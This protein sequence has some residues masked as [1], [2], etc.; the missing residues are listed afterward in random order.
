M[1]VRKEWYMKQLG[2]LFLLGAITHQITHIVVASSL[3][4]GFRQA[5][6]NVS[7]KLGELVRCH[8]CFGTWVGFLT[9][10][11]FQPSFSPFPRTLGRLAR[12][13]VIIAD[14][15][16]IG[17]ASRFY[18]EVLGLMARRVSVAEEEKHLLEAER[19]TVEKMIEVN[20]KE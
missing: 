18:T 16:A 8:L 4:S 14:G 13:A 6:E 2:N 3:F 1:R 11:V 7:P 12:P 15:F 9:A 10:L 20:A 19:E 5:A 17:L